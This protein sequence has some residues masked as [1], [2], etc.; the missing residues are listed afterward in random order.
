MSDLLKAALE[1]AAAGWLVFP[2]LPAS[3]IPATQNGFKDATRSAEQIRAWWQQEPAYNVAIATGE[4][5]GVFVLDVDEKPGRSI[6]EALEQFPKLPDCPTVRTGGGGLQFFFK[7]PQGKHLSISAG[8]L[9]VGIDTRGNGG[10]VVAPPSVHDKTGRAYQWIDCDDE[11]ALPDCPNFII[12][13]LEKQHRAATLLDNEK[14]TG[15]RHDTLMTAAALMRGCGFVPRE[16][17]AALKEMVSRLDLSDGRVVEEREIESIANWVGDKETGAVT[18]NSVS[19]GENAAKLL[20]A[21]AGEAVQEIAN[22]DTFYANPGPFPSEFLNVPGIVNTWC[23]YINRTGMRRQPEMAWAAVLT[24]CGSLIGRRWQ[25]PY[26]GRANVYFLALCETGGGKERARQG[27]KEVMYAANYDDILGPEDF[28]SDAGLIAC[29]SQNPVQLFQIDE[30][31]KL[32]EA[33]KNPRAGVHLTGITSALLK[34]YSSANTI[35]KGKAYAD[36]EKNPIITQ[37]HACLYGTAVPAQTWE[38]LGAAAADDGLLARLWIVGATDNKPKRQKPDPLKIP[39]ALIDQL[40]AWKES[41]P[42]ALASVH[43]TPAVI[44]YSEQAEKILNEF[45]D[46]CD[47]RDLNMHDNPLRKLWTRS[48]QKAEQ[49]AMICAWSANQNATEINDEQALWA[50]NVATYLTESM[51]YNASRYLAANALESD[52]LAVQRYIDNNKEGRSRSEIIRK[53]RKLGQRGVTEVMNLLIEQGS[54]K[55]MEV[56]AK[57]GRPSS[58]FVTVRG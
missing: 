3:K 51:I 50:V 16:I 45:A 20:L 46:E 23:D 17:K 58:V 21:N 1:Y 57:A 22:G 7:Y 44:S 19:H 34:L 38:A 49:L 4:L 56:Q 9:G 41:E 13:R 26:N 31:G 52:L 47:A 2:C 14:L 36:H 29:L 25:T 12:D 55:Q 11:T 43:P 32:L 33:M 10:Y 30:F 39:Q 15:G 18:I 6:D 54:V 48:A 5:S 8:R 35:F 28:A 37:P 27:V 24:A 42:G 53:F 40:R